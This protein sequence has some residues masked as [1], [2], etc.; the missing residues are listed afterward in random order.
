[1]QSRSTII[2]V[3]E[4]RTQA[5][6]AVDEL[7]RAGFRED[8]IGVASRDDEVRTT[9]TVDD[10]TDSE[11]GTGALT[12]AIA[13]AGLG[14]LAGLGILA[15]VIPVIGPAIAG[16]TLGILLSNAAAGAGIAG[17]A[18][19]LIG[20]GIPEEEAGYYENE[21]KTG[22]TLVT[23]KADGRI[24]EAS[25][26][27]RSHGAYD[28]QTQG[29]MAS[30]SGMASSHTS[31][32]SASSHEAAGTT[33]GSTTHRTSASGQER[34][35]LHEEQLHAHK[36]PEQVGEVRVTKEVITEHKTMDVPVQREEVVIERHKPTGEHCTTS[37]ADIRPGEQLRIPVT[38]EQVIVDKQAVAKEEVSIGKRTVQ[39]TERV[40]GD[41]R[42]EQMKVERKGDV[43]VR[44]RGRGN[45]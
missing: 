6:R 14:A 33:P 18:G 28:M 38:E 11:A 16:G 34:M 24:S 19:A 1:M 40:E 10:A 35:V 9:E 36:R 30:T 25:S 7:R 32:T 2:G 15:G 31:A 44:D 5:D 29:G 45:V 27:L 22:R 12:G 37:A 4:T 8:Q 3:F 17:V 42:K 23:V 20:A 26:I 43:E 41:V 21:L 39:G 13:G